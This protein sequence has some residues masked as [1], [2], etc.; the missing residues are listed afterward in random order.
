MQIP[1]PDPSSAES[2]SFGVGP[3]NLKLN[4]Q[5]NKQKQNNSLSNVD[6]HHR[7]FE[8]IWSVRMRHRK[9]GSKLA[10]DIF[11]PSVSAL[12]TLRGH[13]SEMSLIDLKC[14]LVNDS[15]TF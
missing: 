9:E 6:A 11:A 10:G 13:G 2:D 15:F 7:G 14:R 3:G 5:T 1:G 12:W 4:R 8:N